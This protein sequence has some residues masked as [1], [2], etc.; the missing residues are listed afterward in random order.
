MLQEICIIDQ[1]EYMLPSLNIPNMFITLLINTYEN[2][3]SLYSN[4]Y[5]NCIILR[6]YVDLKKFFDKYSD[7]EMWNEIEAL[8]KIFLQRCKKIR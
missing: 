7:N 8:I 6:D 3:E 2:S 5:D 4:L 1:K